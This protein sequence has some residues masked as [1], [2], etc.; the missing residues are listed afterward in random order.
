MGTRTREEYLAMA[1]VPHSDDGHPERDW[2]IGLQFRHY[3]GGLYAIDDLIWN[4]EHDRWEIEYYPIDDVGAPQSST[5][6]TRSFE[7]FFGL[8]EDGRQR[9]VE[10]E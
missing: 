6:Y 5:N 10:V 2:F 9:F 7:N 3:K 1:Q 8:I 4:A